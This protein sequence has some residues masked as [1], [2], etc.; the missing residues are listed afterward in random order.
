MAK[1]NRYK[2]VV[3]LVVDGE[4]T[5]TWDVA[6]DYSRGTRKN[7]W[8]HLRQAKWSEVKSA[9]K[10]ANSIVQAQIAQAREALRAEQDARLAEEA[11]K[12]LVFEAERQAVADLFAAQVSSN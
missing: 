5:E 10:S 2:L 7:D 1:S 11:A 6:F 9:V 3:T 4:A 12:R 8:S